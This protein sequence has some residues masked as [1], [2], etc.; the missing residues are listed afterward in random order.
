MK[1]QANF[2]ACQMPSVNKS[3]KES[4]RP[5]HDLVFFDTNVNFG[6]KFNNQSQ[7]K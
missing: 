4:V 7:I 5:Y 3:G 6:L 2:K 1:E